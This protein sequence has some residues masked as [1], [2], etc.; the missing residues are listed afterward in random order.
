M[1]SSGGAVSKNNST[2][3]FKLLRASSTVSPWLAISNSEQRAT[4]PSSSRQIVAVN[5]RVISSSLLRYVLH[6]ARQ[7]LR[8][9]A[10]VVFALDRNSSLD[11]PARMLARQ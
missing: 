8:R 6:G 11:I 9:S 7:T 2:A 1:V 5:V 3:S 4:K 10:L